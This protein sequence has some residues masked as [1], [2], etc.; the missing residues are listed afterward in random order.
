[1]APAARNDIGS[2]VAYLGALEAECVVPLAN[3]LGDELVRVHDP[4]IALEARVDGATPEPR[5]RRDGSAHTLHPELQSHTPSS[6]SS[7]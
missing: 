6:C 5:V 3:S 1:M 4:D 2:L 7:A